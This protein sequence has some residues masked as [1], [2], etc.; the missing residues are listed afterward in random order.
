M[1]PRTLIPLAALL[2]LGVLA[3]ASTNEPEPPRKRSAEVKL[4]DLITAEELRRETPGTR[5]HELWKIGSI[6]HNLGLIRA[7]QTGGWRSS[8]EAWL[9]G[10]TSCPVMVRR[11]PKLATDKEYADAL[12]FGA[13]KGLGWFD[14]WGGFPASPEEQREEIAKCRRSIAEC[15]KA[16]GYE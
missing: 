16:L 4:T 3:V 15:R 1:K 14:E 11:Y 10:L 7:V 12:F 13:N 5:E 9:D 2:A 8:S 6:G